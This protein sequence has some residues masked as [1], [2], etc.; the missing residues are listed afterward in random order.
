[1]RRLGYRL[2][3]AA[4]EDIEHILKESA[5]LFGPRQRDAYAALIEKAVGL[6]V[7]NPERVG[8]RDRSDLFAGVRSFHVE[9]AAR[10]SGAA[11]HI[12]FYLRG[13]LGD[14]THG[15]IVVRVL[16][17]GMEPARHI[18]ADPASG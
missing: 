15:V 17:E 8:S 18:S 4:D 6:V 3:E 11:S 10:R 1:V 9:L 5:R 12:L 16:Y 2:T 14:G 13:A 7:A